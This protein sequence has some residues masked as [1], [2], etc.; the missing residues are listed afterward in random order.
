MSEEDFTKS[1]TT[2]G[3]AN[4][5]QT[6]QALIVQAYCN[7][8]L[9][10]PPVDFGGHPDLV[11]L[12]LQINTA[13]AKAQ[14]NARTYIDK[15]LP[16]MIQNITNIT[17][18]FQLHQ[19]IPV[20]LPEGSTKEEWLAV[21]NA[22]LDEAKQYQEVAEK[23]ENALDELVKNMNDDIAEFA[24]I[25]NDLNSK[26]D[27]DNSILEENRRTIKELQK[28]LDGAIA[29]IV[30][31]SLA[32]AGG[33]FLI[34]VGSISSFV[35]AGTSNLVTAGGV[36]VVAGGI[37]GTIAAAKSIQGLNDA[38]ANILRENSRIRN[39]VKLATMIE[40]AY[41]SLQENAKKA[42]SAAQAMG[43]AWGLLA[44]DITKVTDNL[45]KGII[46]P[47]IVGKLFLSAAEKSIATVLNDT[48][49][50]KQQLAGIKTFT[51]GPQESIEN[52]VNDV[53]NTVS[54]R[55]ILKP[56]TAATIPRN[57]PTNLLSGTARISMAV[58]NFSESNKRNVGAGL[59]LE[60]YALSVLQ[61]P[62]V[63]FEKAEAPRLDIIENRIN[64]ALVVAKNNA[65]TYVN[66][67]QPTII[68]N[69][70][71]I[72]DYFNIHSVIATTIPPGTAVEDFLSVLTELQIQASNYQD[73]ASRTVDKLEILRSNLQNDSA[74]FSAIV[75]EANEVVTGDEGVLSN[76]QS[77]LN[78]VQEAIRE[79]TSGIVISSLAI[80]GGAIL[81]GIGYCS[82]TVP[83]VVGGI[84]IGVS[85]IAGLSLAINDLVTSQ[86]KRNDL[87]S[88]KSSLQ[89]EVK[90][91]AMLSASYVSLNDQCQEAIGAAA[92]MASSWKSLADNLDDLS[93]ALQHGI[94]SV[95]EAQSQL[96]NSANNEIKQVVADTE[97]I[98]TQMAGVTVES[99][100]SSKKT[101]DV[102]T[103]SF[104]TENKTSRALTVTNR[105][106][107][108]S[109]PPA[110]KLSTALSRLEDAAVNVVLIR[111]LPAS[112][113]SVQS[114]FPN[115]IRVV[116]GEVSKLQGN[117][118]SFCS[119]GINKTNT[120][121]NLLSTSTDQSGGVKSEIDGLVDD[122]DALKQ[123]VRNGHQNVTVINEKFLAIKRSLSSVLSG[124]HDDISSLTA[125]INTARDKASAAK[126]KYYAMIAL[127]P[128]GVAGL[129]AALAVYLT[130]KKE[131]QSLE[132][133]MS[134]LR[135]QKES[136]NKTIACTETFE[137][138]MSI[139]IEAGSYLSN[140]ITLISVEVENLKT[141]FPELNVV[142]RLKLQGLLLEIKTLREDAL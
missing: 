119:S 25:V 132:R 95:P 101:V 59:V 84:G 128:F 135:Q 76:L 24:R 112:V 3:E 116:K 79:N 64:S 109:R 99:G 93:G 63:S 92:A 89:N 85:G 11:D 67:I 50:I 52:V 68:G 21:L 66:E 127:G 134:D 94:I 55:Q 133:K 44:A 58:R 38:K 129:A 4:K 16:M 17:N 126:K 136:V 98:K 34:G 19:V 111:P 20:V 22:I 13:L 105:V 6:A 73:E 51:V 88:K 8:V 40:T 82:G 138:C 115:M 142:M 130:T 43:T 23:T 75:A 122:V 60:A 39:E 91:A 69:I 117:V 141:D 15:I 107:K 5:E 61:Q 27:G 41:S 140:A 120:I 35:T 87:L 30:V 114:D 131:T 110:G 18:Y 45:S 71:N 46:K 118:E 1:A 42:V 121:L 65:R 28:K 53:T 7:S 97:V 81:I 137:T 26:T 83:A 10:Q 70:S 124:L 80:G 62:T 125:Q 108:L 49:I 32:I 104:L 31:S 48:E 57:L 103:N 139:I 12:Q 14:V 86:R 102:I 77:E 78:S 33:V 72:I 106:L 96:L 74:V 54:V 123:K 100:A 36:V 2:V 9:Q 56:S 29:G 37:A 90:L 113:V 47:G